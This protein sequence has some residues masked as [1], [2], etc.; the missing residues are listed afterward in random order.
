RLK[1]LHAAFAR[2]DRALNTAAGQREWNLPGGT[3]NEQTARTGII[4][5]QTVDCIHAVDHGN[6]PNGNINQTVR[7]LGGLYIHELRKRFDF[8]ESQVAQ[9]VGDAIRAI[10]KPEDLTV[11]SRDF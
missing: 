7:L 1:R 9:I 8:L 4:G 11:D 10:L 2:L 3:P 5:F 6:A